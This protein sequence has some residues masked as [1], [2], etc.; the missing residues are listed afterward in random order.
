M[1]KNDTTGKLIQTMQTAVTLL[2]MND[3]EFCEWA[4]RAHGVVITPEQV[5]GYRNGVVSVMLSQ[6]V[7]E[8]IESDK[9]I[10]FKGV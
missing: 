1:K 9:L 3:N 7:N 5:N 6:A 8:A 4:A 2:W 10:E